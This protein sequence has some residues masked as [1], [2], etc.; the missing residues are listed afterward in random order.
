MARERQLRDTVSADA[1][2][3]DRTTIALHWLVALGVVAQWGGA[4]AIDL[5]PKGPLRVDA[6]SAHILLGVTL[7]GLIAVRLWWRARRGVRF[8]P[9]PRPGFAIAA[10][11][12]HAALY[13][14]LLTTLILGVATTWMRGD[15]IF[16]LF[17]I[18]A[19]GDYAPAARHAL[20][21]RIADL[22][23][24]SANWLLGLAGAHAA[25]A[26]AHHYWLKDAVLGR[27]LGRGG[28]PAP[29]SP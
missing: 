17:R 21:N 16:G 20:A 15:S 18:P 19:L 13:A 22:H 12:G 14:L 7:L 27:M 26:L 2:S 6:R 5:F 29:T 28:Q 4:H 11:V 24:L 9:D 23:Q 8:A 25:I 3:Y 1:G 10:R